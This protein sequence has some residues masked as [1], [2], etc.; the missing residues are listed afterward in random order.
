MGGQSVS[1]T[2]G[3]A[4]RR[5]VYSFIDRQNLP[6]VFRAFDFASPDQ[7][8]PKRYQTTVPQQALFALNNPFVIEQARSLLSRPEIAHA[9]SKEEKIRQLYRRALGRNPVA[10]EV[11]LATGFVDNGAIGQAASAWEFG[12]GRLDDTGQSTQ[13]HPLPYFG[14][15]RWSASD[16]MP[17]PQH[18]W[19]MLTRNGGHPGNPEHAAILRWRASEKAT[20]RLEGQLK[21]PA[22]QGDGVRLRLVSSLRGLLGTWDAAAR[23]SVP[24]H[25]DKLEVAEGEALDFII[26]CKADENSDS[27][28]YAPS[29]FDAQSGTEVASSSEEFAGPALDPW[30]AY[31]QV[32]L[33]SNELMFVD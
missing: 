1:L 27:F 15:D 14:K 17:D 33:I 2:E 6:A 3:A 26:D 5:T 4:N 23:S 12:W 19:V 25:L 8:A 16:H 18:G 22:D 32:L 13:F 24:T 9:A 30:T 20:L 10:D 31:A 28:Q 7:H 21:R 11:R 29:L